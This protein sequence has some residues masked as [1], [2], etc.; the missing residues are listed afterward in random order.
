MDFDAEES[1]RPFTPEAAP[2]GTYAGCK[3]YGEF[4]ELLADPG[5]DG[6]DGRRHLRPLACYPLRSA[7]VRAGKDVSVEKR[8]F[9]QQSKRDAC[10]QRGATTL[11]ASR[12]NDSEFRSLPQMRAAVGAV[13][14]RPHRRR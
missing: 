9:A 11:G 5:V 7:A 14:K 12:G 8:H 4:R 10:G 13:L 1:Q 6:P 3:S 2:S